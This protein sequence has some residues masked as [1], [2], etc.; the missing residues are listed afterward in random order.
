MGSQ[1]V[2]HSSVA[3]QQKGAQWWRIQEMQDTWVQSLGLEDALEKEMATHPCL[4]KF[5][6]LLE[7]V[8]RG[9]C[10]KLVDCLS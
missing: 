5:P 8:K 7:S 4:E 3:E 2:Q 1:R 10:L 9:G 6:R